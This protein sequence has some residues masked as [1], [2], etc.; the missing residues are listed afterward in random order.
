MNHIFADMIAEKWL[1]IYMDD[2]GI[3]TKD[4]L[5]LHH[6]WTRCVLLQLQEHGLSL[7]I[8]KCIF[9]AP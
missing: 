6:E 7:K 8:S 9:D 5:T 3:H 2:I 4:N 1:K